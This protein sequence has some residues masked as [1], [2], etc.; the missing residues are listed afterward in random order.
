LNYTPVYFLTQQFN[1]STIQ[2]FDYK[3]LDGFLPSKTSSQ[4]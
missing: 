2:Q 4:R 1:D 3:F